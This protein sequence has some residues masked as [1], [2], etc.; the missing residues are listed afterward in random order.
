[1]KV[2]FY[3]IGCKLN[4]YET[5]FIR[6]LFEEEG[7]EVV[8]FKERADVYVINTC[9]VTSKA[10]S[11]ARQSIRQ[12][13]KRNPDSLI[14]AVGCY[15]QVFPDA[16]KEAGA[17]VIIGVPNKTE[18]LE[19]VKEAFEKRE[20]LVVVRQDFGDFV[21]MPVKKF[22]GYSRAFIKIQD[23]CDMRCS[24][25]IVWKARGPSRSAP[26]RFVIDE[27][28]R[29]VNEGYEEVVLTGTNI[30]DYGKEFGVDLIELLERLTEIEGLKKIRLSSI[31]PVNLNK[32]LIEYIAKNEKVCRHLHIP[33]QSGS[34]RILK[35]M[36]R[37]YTSQDIKGILDEIFSRIPYVGVGLDVIVGFPTETDDDFIKTYRL[38]EEYPIFYMHI[39]SFSPRPGTIAFN[40]KPRVRP[41]IIKKRWEELNELKARKKQE[42]VSK[43]I[44]KD[45]VG[46]VE[47]RP[48][49][50]K[51]WSGISENYIPLL[52]EGDV[53]NFSKKVKTFRAKGMLSDRLIVSIKN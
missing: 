43:F 13:R 15:C 4:Q 42:F 24:Y 19:K 7:W 21:P 46:V 9:T 31:E 18:V 14:V 33:L 47:S 45:I 25:C 36:G 26:L 23:G 52:I 11:K 27:A 10:D 28:K 40:L 1:M 35:L 29:L 38:I 5:E 16:V 8:D 34:D 44:G 51:Y 22:S 3:T 48:Y 2:A 12:A 53:K 30:G 20:K 50:D 41:D 17:D 49:N 37:R 39:F 6:E 32:R